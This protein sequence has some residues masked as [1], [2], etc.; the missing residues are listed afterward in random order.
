MTKS[1]SMRPGQS[2]DWAERQAYWSRRLGRIRLGAE[3]LNDQLAR[4]RLVTIVAS[5]VILFI[6]LFMFMLFLVFGRAD[7]GA[8]VAAVAIVPLAGLAWYEDWKMHH[9]VRQYEEEL[10]HR[11][12][13]GGVKQIG[14]PGSFPPNP[15]GSEGH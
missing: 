1:D 8:I 11:L 9:R 10:R 13:G 5:L 12:M 14:R 7:I 15:D 3:P 4:L 2:G 6:G